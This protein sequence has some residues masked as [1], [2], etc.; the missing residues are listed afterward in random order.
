MPAHSSAALAH[1]STTSPIQKSSRRRTGLAAPVTGS[2]ARIQRASDDSQA[3]TPA[4][5]HHH[6]EKPS[7]K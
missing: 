6:T 1:I 5:T 7:A 2:P 3:R 4:A